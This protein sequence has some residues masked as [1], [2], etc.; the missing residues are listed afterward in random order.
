MDLVAKVQEIGVPNHFVTVLANDSW[1]NSRHLYIIRISKKCSIRP[2]ETTE[3]F[4]EHSA[5]MKDLLDLYGKDSVLGRATG[6]W[7]RSEFQNRG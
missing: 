2:V 3:Y 4:L 6:H 5:L 7:Y 1:P